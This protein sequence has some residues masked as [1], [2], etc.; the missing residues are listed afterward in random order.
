MGKSGRLVDCKA[1]EADWARWL[2]DT[3]YDAPLTGDPWSYLAAKL[4]KHRPTLLLLSPE[5]IEQP[6]QTIKGGGRDDD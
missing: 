5:V 4:V 2:R 3:Y 6:H 1:E